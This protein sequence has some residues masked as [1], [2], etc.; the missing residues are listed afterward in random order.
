MRLWHQALI[1]YLDHQRLLGQNRECCA[2]RGKGW[3]RKHAT[4]DY[5]FRHNLSDLYYYH[6]FVI[7]EMY[8][9]GYNVAK[10]WSNINYRGKVLGYQKAY[11]EKVFQFKALFDTTSTTVYPEHDR[12]YLLECIDLLKQKNAPIDFERLEKELNIKGEK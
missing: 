6:L 1:P 2:L 10:D 12:A 4:V 5:V 3:G 11:E 8:K 7:Q 9:R